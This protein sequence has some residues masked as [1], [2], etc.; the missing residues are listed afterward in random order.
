MRTPTLSTTAV[1]VGHNEGDWQIRG[2]SVTDYA[3]ALEAMSG[4]KS[5][6]V[7]HQQKTSHKRILMAED[8]NLV[9][10]SLAA[11]LESEGYLVDEACSGR[12][13][14]V[15]AIA[16][17]PDLVL[18]DLNMP[19]WD[20][21]TAFSQLDRITPLLPVIV[22]TARPNQYDKAVRLVVDALMEKPLSIPVLMRA[23]NRFTSEDK[24]SHVSRITNRGFV[25]E[26]LDS[27]HA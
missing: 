7:S 19:D 15:R 1:L 5:L 27:E 8:D 26:L 16:H 12:E 17:S 2:R 14:V 18:L 13:A 22:I 24:K 3:A 4:S 23:I 21:W 6:P 11:V 9:R 10:G 25:T 20:G